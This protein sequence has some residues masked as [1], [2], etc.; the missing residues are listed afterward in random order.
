MQSPTIDRRKK[1]FTLIETLVA[2]TILLLT[3]VGP[4]TIAQKGIQNAYY[5]TDQVTAV[6]LAQEA[7]EAIREHRDNAALEAY[8]AL[9][10]DDTSNWAP[11]GCSLGCAYDIV[12]DEFGSC[13]TNNGCNL[14]VDL[15]GRYTHGLDGTPSQFTRT[16]TIGSAI[17]G[18]VPVTVNVSWNAKI[19]GGGPH[20]LTLQTWIYDHYQRYEN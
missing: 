17:G 15:N 8:D 14:N 13:E 7:I 10:G 6:F 18:G 12:D 3:I 16:V 19:F 2:I 9:L 20:T 4:M 11:S 1:G 5:A